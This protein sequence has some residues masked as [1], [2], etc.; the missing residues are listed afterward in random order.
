MNRLNRRAFLTAAGAAGV[1]GAATGFGVSLGSGGARAAAGT[2]P[3]SLALLHRGREHGPMGAAGAA[4]P[5]AAGTTLETA[6]AARGHAG[7]RR[8]AKGPGWK[9]VIRNELAGGKK[10][11]TDRRITLAAFA[12]F[13]DLHI[14]DVQ[15]PLRYEYLRSET[16]SAWRPQEALTIPATVALIERVNALRHAPATGA[17]LSF[18]MTTGDNTDNNSKLELDWFLTAMSGGPIV[19]NSGDPKA[20]EGVQNSGLPLYW[21]PES[22]HRDSD[23]KI[24]FP[25]V[26][27]FLKAAIREAKSPGLQLPW[28]S[29][30]GN[31][32]LLP[33][34]CYGSSVNGFFADFAVGGRKLEELPPEQAA[35]AWRAVKKGLDPKGRDFED[36]LR[37]HHKKMR[38]ITPDL[39][40]A[41]FSRREYVE[42]HLDPRNKGA[43][44]VGHGYTRANLMEGHLYYTFEVAPG[45]LGISL[46]TT[47]PGGDYRGS[48]GTAQ[49]RWLERMLKQH[50]DAYTIVFSHHTSRTMTN[51]QPDPAAP[52]EKRHDG[53]EVLAL[54]KDHPKVL[55]WI[56]GH[57]HKNKITP[58]GS[59]WEIST[60][61]HID[62]P[63]LARIIELT[64]NGDGTLSLFTTLIESAAPDHADFTD[65]TQTGLAALYRELAFNAPAPDRREPLTGQPADR[66][67][68]LLLQK[69]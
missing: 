32:D 55:A 58:H 67:T 56:N 25:R 31:H 57:S 46:D 61:S 30:I 68:E 28:Y 39:R 9:R 24:G 1:A 64:D 3:P 2:H 18:V 54:L 44:P 4:A 43:G 29:T 53:D 40:R 69:P 63:Q 15:H 50:K 34:G 49:L 6:A 48:V 42:A 19:P 21:Q 10:G 38:G 14:V 8:L 60:A 59:L 47:D 20:Y 5:T 16:A 7:Y 22:D 62:Y 36:L 45:V 13:T 33:G 26:D 65:L 35:R 17:P 37:T 66:N 41:P 23:K 52:K 11:R 51:T 27:G 12:Q